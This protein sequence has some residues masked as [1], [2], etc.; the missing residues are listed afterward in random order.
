MLS[1]FAPG[2]EGLYS[3]RVTV[4]DGFRGLHRVKDRV[5][6]G[7]SGENAYIYLVYMYIQT[8][9]DG[10]SHGQQHAE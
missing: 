9:N 4:Y 10:E 8:P 3:V 2:I 7:L 1:A 6:I 5:N